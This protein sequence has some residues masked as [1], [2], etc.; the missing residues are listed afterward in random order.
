MV[1]RQNE[2]LARQKE[3]LNEKKIITEQENTILKIKNIEAEVQ[4]LKQQIQPHFLF[5]SLY[6]LKTI[7]SGNN[8]GEDYLVKLCNLL[9]ISLSSD[10][11]NII[12]IKDEVNFCLDYLEMQKIRFGN[13]LQYS[14][15][16]SE[17][18]QNAGFVLIFSLQ[19]L[20]EN[21]IKHNAFTE[22]LPLNICVLNE[23]DRII[24]K[25]NFQN[26]LTTDA[27]TGIGLNNIS[28]RYK[29]LT[30]DKVLI[31]KTENEFLVSIKIIYNEDSSN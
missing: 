22:E 30:G 3:E 15:N 14:I 25:N 17:E 4:H 18:V 1:E 27:T 6:T 12:K 2:L 9:R 5:N 29:I 31:V 24:V 23:N 7:I 16:I 13:A 19:Q 20:I 28:E 10:D 26:K 21:A 11:I 8:D